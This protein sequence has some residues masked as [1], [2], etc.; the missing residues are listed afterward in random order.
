M[1]IKG[2]FY[3]PKG[4]MRIVGLSASGV[5]PYSTERGVIKKLSSKSR[6]RLALFATENTIDWESMLTLT[7]GANYREFYGTDVKSHL[8]EALRWLKNSW[9]G[10]AYLWFIEFQKRGA[11]HFHV[12]LNVT[13]DNIDRHFMAYQWCRLVGGG[14]RKE[15]DK[16]FY[17]HCK[18][19]C[20]DKIREVDGARRYVLKYASKTEQKTVPFKYQ[21]VGRFW[22]CNARVK[23]SIPKPTYVSIDETNLRRYLSA[24][25]SPI[26]DWQYLPTIVYPRNVK[27]VSRET[28]DII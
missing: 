4:S 11:P 16:I 27:N 10:I 13:P 20:W 21:N 1:V 9:G 5:P 8:Y 26:A 19:Q 28:I 24:I 17:Q 18:I 12:L 2:A 6:Q 23:N 25:E 3:Y 15:M 7:Y 14:N 22:G